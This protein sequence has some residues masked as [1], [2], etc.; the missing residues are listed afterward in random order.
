V[1]IAASGSDTV[2]GSDDARPD[3]PADHNPVLDEAELIR[4]ARDAFRFGPDGRLLTAAGTTGAGPS[5]AHTDPAVLE[6][7]RSWQSGDP[8]LDECFEVALVFEAMAT[9]GRR[10]PLG[11][12][13]STDVVDPQAV[14]V[15]DADAADA[16]VVAVPDERAPTEDAPTDDTFTAIMSELRDGA[17]LGGTTAHLLNAAASNGDLNPPTDGDGGPATDDARIDGTG[18][19]GEGGDG[20][21][22][23][24]HGANGHGANGQRVEE[25]GVAGNGVAGNGV[26]ANGHA[27]PDGDG[28]VGIDAT[29]AGVGTNGAGAD[30]DGGRSDRTSMWSVPSTRGRPMLE[31]P[32]PID[33]DRRSE[34]NG[35]RDS[36]ETLASVLGTTPEVELAFAQTL[37]GADA[38]MG[39]FRW[40]SGTALWTNAA[41]DE[42]LLPG[43]PAERT[44]VAILD[45]WSQAHFLVRILP[46]LLRRGRWRGQ[47]RL[48]AASGRAETML[49]TLVGH[50]DERGGTDAVSV[51][52]MPVTPT[53]MPAP[54]DA[55]L[56][57]TTV[58]RADHDGPVPV[59]GADP[60]AAGPSD[61]LFSALVQHVSDLIVVTDV[62]GRITFASPAAQS[63][64][65]LAPAADG[66]RPNLLAIMHPDNRPTTLAMLARQPDEAALP[67]NPMRVLGVD[68]TWR[69]LSGVLTD[70]TGAPAVGGFVLNARDVTDIVRAEQSITDQAYTDA[71]TGLANRV[72]LLDRLEGNAHAAPPEPCALVV[73]GLDHLRRVDAEHGATGVEAVLA[74]V[75]ARLAVVA[76]GLGPD[77]LA[78][79]LHSDEFAVFIP[80]VDEIGAAVAVAGRLRLA[81]REPIRVGDH[82]LTIT[83]SMGVATSASTTLEDGFDEILARADL[84]M[85]EAKARGRDRTVAYDEKLGD[86]QQHRRGIDQQLRR[87]IDSDGLRIQFQPIVEL[88]TGHIVAAEALLRVRGED[89]ELLSPGAFVEAAESNGL[90]SRLGAAVLRTTCEQATALD[91]KP[92]GF[93]ISVNV[94]P[95]QIADPGFARRVLTILDE[96]GLAPDRLSLEITEGA[97]VGRDDAS[98]TNIISL[99]DEG[100]RL[101]L[102]E[103]GGDA[104][105]GYLRRFPLDFVKID[106]R[107]IAG[108]GANYVDGTIVRATIELAHKLGLV[109]V[110][111]GVELDEQRRRLEQ[112]GCD[113]AQGYLFGGAISSVELSALLHGRR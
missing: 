72:R 89:G 76:D 91:L 47:L 57:A 7:A 105:L 53:S 73:L 83:G 75:G 38:P 52:A 3:E 88:S 17:P 15:A 93:P 100:V 112:L 22:A 94:S 113:R 98:E 99:R 68:G 71:L 67:P 25:N 106:R 12:G 97:F 13:S 81:L 18:V 61:Q 14:E 32:E 86:R 9:F 62:H 11:D 37:G 84:A 96:T 87:A 74:T 64:L 41:L 59:P 8:V 39:L 82:N 50:E 101:G 36:I 10:A 95:R 21:G 1:E 20:H 23:N 34:R 6:A 2:A 70:L 109:T 24:G 4:R 56:G 107:L 80:R 69:D 31:W 19:R 26:E 58:G 55:A 30:R 46:E 35:H 79:R 103:F 65:D 63:L 42:W 27:D 16:T 85:R 49:V 104:S 5:A 110:A 33:P 51:F 54:A 90:I 28:E 45:E 48:A 40:P 78:A 108:L 102:D 29:S 66:V 60:L 44:L 92:G 111:V 43:R 77:G